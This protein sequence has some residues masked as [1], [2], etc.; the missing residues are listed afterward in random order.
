M[1]VLRRTGS[2]FLGRLWEVMQNSLEQNG[3]HGEPAPEFQGWGQ[4][5][6]AGDRGPQEPL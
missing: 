6:I 2:R 4:Q 5:G 3:T 1:D